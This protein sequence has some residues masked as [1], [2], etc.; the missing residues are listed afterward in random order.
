M[1]FLKKWRRNG[2]DK[3]RNDVNQVNQLNHTGG[4]GLAKREGG[5]GDLA[6][7]RFREEIDKA[8]ERVW[9]DLDRHDPWSAV[10]SL[11]GASVGLG[12]M[13][14]DWPAIDMAEDDKA[15]TLRVDVPGLDPKNLDVEVSDGA[16]TIRGSRQDEWSDNSRG[17]FRRER[18]AGSFARSVP[19]PPYVDP[20]RVE[21]RYDKGT[22]TLTVPKIPEKAPRRV[23]VTA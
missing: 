23:K 8:F 7:S 16:L 4:T 11:A 2:N 15:V 3:N 9:R 17:V 13:L 18:T 5:G 22:L 21:A 10:E 12:G 14:A 1:N 19:L 20:D 6:L